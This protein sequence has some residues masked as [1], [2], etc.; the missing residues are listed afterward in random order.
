MFSI[1]MTKLIRAK[2]VLIWSDFQNIIIFIRFLHFK[3]AH[4]LHFKQKNQ[5]ENIYK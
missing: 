2:R 5:N 3:M 4:F 1:Q